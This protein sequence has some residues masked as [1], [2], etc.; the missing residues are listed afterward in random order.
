MLISKNSGPAVGDVASLRLVTG[1]E[2]IGKVVENDLTSITITKPILLAVQMVQSSPNAQPQA[3]LQF[4]PFMVG[5][6]E[7]DNF[8]ILKDKLLVAPMKARKDVA[9]NYIQATTGLAVPQN[10]LLKA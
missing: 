4:A 6:E 8:L 3:A 10:S 5:A 7:G 1:E 2:I 9:S